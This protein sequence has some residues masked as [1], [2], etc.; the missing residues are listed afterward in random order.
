[1]NRVAVSDRSGLV[2]HRLDRSI[3]VLASPSTQLDL[4]D[5][6]PIDCLDR[7]SIRS[8]VLRNLK[9]IDD[10]MVMKMVL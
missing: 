10:I 7:L 1:M 4:T 8:F 6:R 3:N 5:N 2:V 9:T